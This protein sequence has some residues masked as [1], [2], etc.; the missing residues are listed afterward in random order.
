M[1]RKIWLSGLALAVVA[2]V[3]VAA[4]F[5]AP[6]RSQAGTLVFGA[7]S[8]PVSLDAAV[9]SDGESFR[10]TNQIVETLVGLKPGTTKLVPQLATGW[11]KSNGG[12]TW[13]F[14]LRK[15]VRFHD[16][17]PFNAAAV[18]ANFDRWYNFTGALQS[19][20]ASYYYNTVF[21]G[22]RKPEKG[23][24]GPKDALYKS[25]KAINETTAQINL[26]YAFGP[27]L[28]A[29]TINPFG[30]QSPTAMKKYGADKG[31][32]SKDGVY[33]P[34]GTYGTPGGVSAGTGPFKVESWKV[35]DKLVLVRN[36]EYW[37]KKAILD[38][39]IV[40]AIADNAAR[41]QALQTG[42]IQ[43]YDLV[44]PQDIKT[45]QRDSDLK[46]LDR[47][48]FNV[49]YVTINQAVE[50]FDNLKV[51]QAVAYGL[52]RA[53][54]V[55]AFYAGRGEVAHQFMPPS[56]PGYSNGVPK[57][58]YNPAKAKQL[59]EEAGVTL[60]LEVEFWYPTDVSRPYMPAPEKNFQAFAA[61]LNKAGFKVIPK[62]A[63]WRPDYLGRVDAGTA[64]A[65][66]LIGWT[67]DYA[68]ADNFVGTFF[69]TEQ[70][71]WGFDDP[72]LRDVLERALVETNLEIRG[73]LY[74]QANN[75][76]MRNVY[77]VPYVHTKP[78]LAFAKNVRGYVASPTTTESF[79]T[80]TVG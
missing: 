42:E 14:T 56:V 63:P 25:C 2:L 61:S 15:N 75:I 59:L 50:P 74:R 48:A 16:G 76:I 57:Y 40:V 17:T 13:T 31:R 47:P 39:V 66:N 55:K 68:D 77:G 64:G 70:S 19:S 54:V 79:A 73:S 36:N 45:I 32:L 33:V 67:G 41:L 7:A 28:G 38:R 62:S 65:L 71:Q 10:V 20:S 5:A 4:A 51:R 3:A 35:G 58:T 21:V 29:L 6:T 8:D 46:V 69:R 80:V 1:I 22:F 24:K 9:I 60:P 49:G 23:A 30:I 18:C 43:G 27:F 52:D 78:A 44:E 12:K 26:R 34:L 53:R 11:K 37:G 72:K